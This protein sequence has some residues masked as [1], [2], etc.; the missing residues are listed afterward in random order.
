[1]SALDLAELAALMAGVKPAATV[2]THEASA[3]LPPRLDLMRLRSEKP[4]P[5]PYVI[6]DHLRAGIPAI[7][8]APGGVG[9]TWFGLELGISIA[10]QRANAVLLNLP[11]SVPGGCLYLS[12]EDDEQELSQRMHVILSLLDEDVAA[13]VA[14]RFDARPLAGA[15]VT[16]G[17]EAW[18]DTIVAAALA[19]PD[20]RLIVLDTLST[21]TSGVEENDNTALALVVQTMQRMSRNSALKSP[22]TVL[23]MHHPRGDAQSKALAVSAQNPDMADIM[24]PRG[25][26]VIKSNARWVGWM[27]AMSPV[28]AEEIGIEEVNRRDYVAFGRGK[29]NGGRQPGVLWFRRNRDGVLLSAPEIGSTSAEDSVSVFGRLARAAEKQKRPGGTKQ[30]GR[31]N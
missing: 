16:L 11:I 14:T 30:T 3:V 21:L 8:A 25:A 1:M 13:E 28:D 6:D 12:A 31:R 5:L 19:V 22:V 9:K 7:L 17:S 24:A 15:G 2:G 23:V 26:S 4:A 18:V 10:S 29:G 20:L 27:C